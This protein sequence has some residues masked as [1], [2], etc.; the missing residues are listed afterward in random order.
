MRKKILLSILSVVIL[1][2]ILTR[3]IFAQQKPSS[4]FDLTVSPPL[5]ELNANPG[6]TLNERFRVR[7]NDAN[8]VDLQVS[9]SRLISD[10]N[11]GSPIPDSSNQG[12]ELSWVTFDPPTFTAMPKEWKD[13]NFSIN[14]PKTAAFGYYYVIRI[15][16][17]D[18]SVLK[19]SGAKIS[20]ELLVVVL[21]TVKSDKAVSKI[22]LID[23]KPK[24]FVSEYLPAS[25]DIKLANK[26]N[27]HIKPRGNIFIRNVRQA[28]VAMLDVNQSL[29]SILPGGVRTF[30]SSWGDGFLVQEPVM[31]DGEIKINKD[32]TPVTH[33]VIN[34]NKLTSFRIGPYTAS[35]LMVYDDGKRDQ[36]IEG[37]ATFWIIPYTALAVILVSVVILFILIRFILKWYIRREISR[38][39]SNK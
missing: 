1:G 31:Q 20:G 27:V 30:N 25:F 3:T 13:V 12:E 8:P 15:A 28:D 38:Q 5:F 10:P 32:G 18:S 6:D 23:F 4:R 33:L 24:N 19:S 35:L 14:I 17:K 16:P 21:L 36:T 26:G 2:F 37:T 11:S 22:Q 39:R 9:V 7:N 29:G 34:W